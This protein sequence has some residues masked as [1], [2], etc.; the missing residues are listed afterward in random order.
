[1]PTLNETIIQ[2]FALE[3]A[4]HDA[5][6]YVEDWCKIPL[7]DLADVWWWLLSAEMSPIIV[8]KRLF[9]RLCYFP[10][11]LLEALIWPY[12][13]CAYCGTTYRISCNT[14][15][16]IWQQVVGNPD[17]CLCPDCFVRLAECKGIKL[18]TKDVEI[19]IFSP[20]GK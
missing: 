13:S 20:K 8:F 17:L 16:E 4:V 3:K 15:D 18:T 7:E 6:G 5:F 19:W 14:S 9:R 10:C 12:E 2:F 1:M 11:F